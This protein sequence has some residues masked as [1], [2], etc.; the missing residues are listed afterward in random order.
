MIFGG[1]SLRLLYRTGVA[2]AAAAVTVGVAAVTVSVAAV[3]VGVA[4]AG[5]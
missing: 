5:C 3:T 4:L 1:A 2:V